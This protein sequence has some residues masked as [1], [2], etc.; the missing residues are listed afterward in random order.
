MLRYLIVLVLAF[1]APPAFA[2]AQQ[3]TSMVVPDEATVSFLMVLVPEHDFGDAPAV[4]RYDRE[5]SQADQEAMLLIRA[6][7]ASPHVIEGASQLALAMMERGLPEG[8]SNLAVP[9]TFVPDRGQ[10][11]AWSIDALRQ[12]RAAT[13]TEIPGLGT[14]RSLSFG[15]SALAV[16]ELGRGEVGKAPDGGR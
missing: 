16:R 8:A 11:T 7:G 6:A 13:P 2:S 12:L 5:G 3:T 9:L 14:Y 4:L 15:V 1:A 10:P